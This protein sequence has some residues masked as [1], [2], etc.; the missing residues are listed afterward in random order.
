[1][2]RSVII[3]KKRNTELS[4]KCYILFISDIKKKKPVCLAISYRNYCLPFFLN[5]QVSLGWNF[6]ALSDIGWTKKNL[7]TQSYS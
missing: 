2:N 6:D 1:M 3:F 4:I 7:K 5:S